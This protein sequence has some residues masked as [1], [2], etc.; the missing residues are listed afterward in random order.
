M[1]VVIDMYNG[2][3]V[4]V[5]SQCVMIY[6]NVPFFRRYVSKKSE[7]HRFAEKEE[8]PPEKEEHPPEKVHAHTSYF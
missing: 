7:S 2:V 1:C 4:L 6:F 8:H 5:L 3:H